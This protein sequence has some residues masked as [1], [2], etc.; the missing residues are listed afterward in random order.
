MTPEGVSEHG[1]AETLGEVLSQAAG[2]W[3]STFDAID[4]PILLLDLA[5]RV[6]RLNL[7]AQRLSGR[8]FEELVGSELAVVGPRQPWA[9]ALELAHEVGRYR[10]PASGQVRDETGRDWELAASLAFA[11][12]PGEERVVLFARDVSALV[13]LEASLRRAEGVAAIGTLVA[14]IAHEVRNPLFAISAIVETIAARVGSEAGLGEHVST[15]R[16]EVGRLSG[17]LQE[18]FDYGRSGVVELERRDIGDVVRSTV[19][20]MK[21]SLTAS[22]VTLHNGVPPRF[23]ELRLDAER[24]E[25]ALENLI[26]NALQH[27]P[28]GSSVVVDAWTSSRARSSWI[29]IAVIDSGPGFAPADLPRIFEPFFT[30]RTG[31]TGLGLSMVKRIAEAHG[32][33]VTA[34]NRPEGGALVVLSLAMAGTSTEPA[35]P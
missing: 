24:I 17:M 31:G 10:A 19:D 23:A 16:S 34:E 4:S 35:R 9:M 18:L 25:R 33:Q 20:R 15:L 26:Q 14:G 7:S 21:P 2:E 11:E 13:Q 27:S 8:S 29:D 32:G 12:A 3:R 1:K 30:R 28:P 5:G 6:V 22:R